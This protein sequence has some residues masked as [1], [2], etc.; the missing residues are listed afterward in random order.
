M[1]NYNIISLLLAFVLSVLS[2]QA[3]GSSG[4]MISPQTNEIIPPTPSSAQ[5]IRYQSPQPALA[6]GAVNLSIPLYTIDVEGLQIPFTLNYHTSGIKPLDDPFPCG[7][8]WSL[9]PALRIVRTVRGRPDEHFDYWGDKISHMDLRGDA[10]VGYACMVAELQHLG[11]S[12]SERYDPEK[13]IFTISL[14]SGTY[15]RV[16]KKEDNGTISFLGGEC[17]N[18]IIVTSS[19]TLENITVTDA[20]GIVYHFGGNFVEIPE[21][22]PFDVKFFTTSWG[23]REIVLPSGR[24]IDFGWLY[25]FHPEKKIYGGDS[26]NDMFKNLNRPLQYEDIRSDAMYGL[27][28]NPRGSYQKRMHLSSVNFPGGIVAFNYQDTTLSSFTVIAKNDTV[29]KIEFCFDKTE[30]KFLKEIQIRGEGKYTF[31]YD[32]QRF[33]GSRLWHRQ[34]WWGFYNGKEPKRFPGEICLTPYLELNINSFSGSPTTTDWIGHADRTPDENAMKAGI[35]TKVTY[36]TGGSSCFEYESHRFPKMRIDSEGKIS[37]TTDP[38]LE[39]GGGLRVISVATL[40]ENND[41]LQYNTFRYDS[42]VVTSVPSAS[43]FVSSCYG[44]GL[45]SSN[46]VVLPFEYRHTFVSHASDYMIN[47]IGETDIWY[48]KVTEFYREGKI[49]YNFNCINP[50]SEEKRECGTL[51]PI[52]LNNVFSKGPMLTK[53]TVFRECSSGYTPVETVNYCYEK[54][55]WDAID[56]SHISRVLLQGAEYLSSSP[57][58]TDGEKFQYADLVDKPN[59]KRYK[60]ISIVVPDHLINGST[61]YRI[62][63]YPL[64]LIS[65]RLKSKTVTRHL[66]NG[67]FSQTETYEYKPGTSIITSVVTTVPGDSRGERIDLTYPSASGTSVERSMVS[68]N[69]VSVPIQT[70]RTFGDA[71]TTVRHQMKHYGNRVYRPEKTWL[72]RGVTTEWL[73]G[74]YDYDSFGNIRQY[75]GEDSVVTTYLWGYGGL[76]PVYRIDGIR[77]AQAAAYSSSPNFTN[78]SAELVTPALPAGWHVT[79]ALWKPLVGM[80]SLRRPDGLTT[81]YGYDS[82]GRL[83][84]TAIDG[85]G[86]VEGYSYHVQDDGHNYMTSGVF[87][88]ATGTS[89]SIR[90][91][92]NYDGLGRESSRLTVAPNPNEAFVSDFG[93]GISAARFTP[94]LTIKD[95]GY[96]AALTQ[97][98]A[99]DRPYRSW[100]PVHVNGRHPSASEISTAAR[101]LY[102]TSYAYSTTYYEASPLAVTAGSRKAG[103]E[104]HDADRRVTVRR[105]VNTVSGNY[106]CYNYKPYSATQVRGATNYPAGTLTVEEITDE[107]GHVTMTFTDRRGLTV[108]TRE[109]C[110]GDWNDTRYVYNDFGDLT[111]VIQPLQ[112]SRTVPVKATFSYEYDARG[113]CVSKSLPGGEPTLCRYDIGGRLFAEQ[114]GNLRAQGRWLFHFYD[115]LGREVVQSLASATEQTVGNMQTLYMTAAPSSR[116]VT[117]ATGGYIIIGAPTNFNLTELAE[118]RYY[119]DYASVSSVESGWASY[120]PPAGFPTPRTDAKGLLTAV[121]AEKRLTVTHYDNLGREV[122][123]ARGSYIDFPENCRFTRYDYEGKPVE[124]R[125]VT[126]YG[127][128]A[129]EQRITRRYYSSGHLRDVTVRQ[130][131]DTARFEYTY[132]DAGRISE[133]LLSGRITRTFG[134][135][136]NGW[137]TSSSATVVRSGLPPVIQLGETGGAQRASSLTPT[138]TATIFNEKLHYAE[139]G[140][141]STARYDGKISGR[142]RDGRHTAYSYDSHGRLSASTSG[143]SGPISLKDAPDFSTE[144]TYDR[145]ANIKTMMRRG[146]VDIVGGKN[147]YGVQSDL[148][149]TYTLNRLTKMEA[150]SEGAD[151]EGRT[152]VSASGTVTGFTYDSNGNLTADPSRGILQ[153][154]YNRL[155]QPTDVYLTGGQRQHITYDG[156]GGKLSV[157]YSQVPEAMLTSPET[158]YSDSEYKLQSRRSYVG[159]HVFRDGK[160]EYSAFAGGYF[161]PQGGTMYYLTDWQ[162]NN[163][164]VAD[165]RGNVVQET[166]YYPYGEP[167]I[168]PTGQRYLFGGKEREHAGGRNAYDFGARILTPYGCWSTPDPLAEKF[169][170]I[171]PYSY[172]GG[173][174]INRVDEDGKDIYEFNSKGALV[175]IIKELRY[176]LVSITTPSGRIQECVFEYG[177]IYGIKKIDSQ[178]APESYYFKVKG[179][180]NSDD[181]YMMLATNTSSEWG[182]VRSE[183]KITGAI[184]NYIGTSQLEDAELTGIRIMK[185]VMNPETE[186]LR[187]C[188]HSHPNNSMPSGCPESRRPN[189][190]DIPTARVVQELYPYFDNFEVLRVRSLRIDRYN[191]DSHVYD[192]ENYPKEYLSDDIR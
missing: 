82:A 96:Y 174:P 143:S 164:V 79:K 5:Q 133:T 55:G 83:I 101:S 12:I 91:I 89:A 106:S 123:V 156:L 155:N 88:S 71:V 63:C 144:Y 138:Y 175:N 145:N 120:T 114:D 70:R 167:T 110:A 186:I 124:E 86:P 23:I 161:D 139:S 92:I 109:G 103:K 35:L 9:Q 87:K 50:P 105:L 99:M 147:V 84:R 41:T 142:T 191:K 3:Q 69:I 146:I 77:Y 56:N 118:A 166:T 73:A 107:E 72:R 108:M 149:M 6:T 25:F 122:R 94:P 183:N 151:Y 37:E 117:D 98:D 130:G 95:G 160:L 187:R 140:S 157:E 20:Q 131:A 132:D 102:G 2:A 97:Y 49:E 21:H 42:V 66:E 54:T 104:W 62:S 171:S 18:E 40:S 112:T 28:N 115:R 17:D 22:G 61:P 24:T 64:N 188:I 126:E 189:E 137:L 154:K 53:K 168:E 163:A 29:H 192:F 180:E 7:Y 52:S 81:T 65:E 46:G 121:L 57:D 136:A 90:E 10:H 19:G 176:D 51:Y 43:T 85:H 159:P 34:D 11:S 129:P 119:D 141:G 125:F 100:S 111:N 177:T 127:L 181:I 4:L 15:T 36:P 158:V 44:V 59:N 150:D 58:F 60:Y 39:M 38:W 45:T 116:P 185:R 32:P 179:V 148:T 134:Y 67:D 153:I 78:G 16:M 27:P 182:L 172:C 76:Y 184:E 30:N 74:E 48:S 93:G 169:Y 135:N 13:D 26:Y 8:G 113:R 47:H 14:P 170:S 152:G 162:G 1:K 165:N 178:R 173:D 33:D 75:R 31:E 190:G 68:D 128:S 80:A